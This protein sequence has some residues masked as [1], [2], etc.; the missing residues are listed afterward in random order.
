MMKT[1]ATLVLSCQQ[2]VM[3]FFAALDG[4]RMQEVADAMADDGVWHRQGKALR[5]PAEVASALAQR[6]AGRVTAHLVQNLVVDLV[7][8]EHAHARYFV[9]TY[10]HDAPERSDS[11][12]P[13]GTPFAIAAYEDRLQR[14]GDAWLVQERRS[15]PVF[16]S[17]QG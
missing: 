7:D 1:D 15:R 13:L 5:G 12:A 6:P 11:P 3:R 14:R 16:A 4:G 2:A 8:D 10:R 17:A 9:L